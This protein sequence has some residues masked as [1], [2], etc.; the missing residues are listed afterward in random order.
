MDDNLRAA[1]AE[2]K[3]RLR[4][5]VLLRR[6]VR[7]AAETAEMDRVRAQHLID[8]LGNNLGPDLVVACY[9]SRP[10]EPG[11]L[12]AVGMLRAAGA[13]VLLPAFGP[14]ASAADPQW[15]WYA[16]PEELQRG[17]FG[18]PQP[19]TE[20]LRPQTLAEAQVIICPGLA[21][22][23]SGD[24]LGTGGGWYDRALTWSDPKAAVVLLLN[25]NE[26]LDSLPTAENDVPVDVIIT[27][28][29]VIAVE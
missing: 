1:I 11:T 24:R 26:V 20:R 6:S 21:A 15:A 17:P 12:Q 23:A 5:A 14:D 27:E 28:E 2:S 7:P 18:I 3:Q 29:R 25:D 10:G 9:L 22:T 16:G 19:T 4:Q 13:K 8:F